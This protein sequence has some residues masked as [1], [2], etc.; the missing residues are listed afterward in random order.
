MNP[1]KYQERAIQFALAKKISYC[2]MDMGLGKTL[3]AILWAK[4][5]LANDLAVPGV[6]V[7]APLRPMSTTWPE[8]LKKWAPELSYQTLHGPTKVK[9]IRTKADFYLINYEGL[10]W[11]LKELKMI[12]KATKKLP[13]RAIILDEG[14]RAKSHSTKRHK[15]LNILSDVA[16]NYKLMLSGTPAPNSLLD[17]WAQYYFLDKG[18]RLGRKISHY[19]DRHFNQYE[20]KQKKFKSGKVVEQQKKIFGYVIKHAHDE[21]IYE[22]IGDITFRLD[23]KDYLEIPE[24][25]IN[26]IV[27]PMSSKLRAQYNALENLFFIELEQ[28]AI[29]AMNAPSLAMKLRQFVQGGLYT[30]KPREKVNG[31]RPYSV[32]HTEKLKV[33]QELVEDANGNGIL[34][35]I[36]FR[37]E[38]DMIRKVFPDAPVIAGGTKPSTAISLINKWNRGEI[39]LLL[40][41]PASISDGVNLQSGSHL[42]VWYG[43]TWSLE[44]YLQFNARLHRQGQTK[45]VIIH[46]LIME[47]TID[48]V[49]MK[50]LE[51]KFE[52]QSELLKYLKELR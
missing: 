25:V 27:I 17:L 22:K 29:E 51:N 35:A 28:S 33:L 24:K 6:L 45:T 40:C 3:V 7:V 21:L 49:I 38:L 20:I 52:G 9:A 12:F 46:H 26:K 19:R 39:P 37:F 42:I 32:V 36:Q 44:K 11:L 18:K 13:F 30:G 4:H 14:N 23:A 8:E 10:A 50:A 16:P 15:V 43:L 5:I 1:H 48:E 34:C 2:A 31:E 41:H 47:G